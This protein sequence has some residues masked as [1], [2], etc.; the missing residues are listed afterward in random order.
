VHHARKAGIAAETPAATAIGYGRS[1]PNIEVI[2]SDPELP[3][4]DAAAERK[5]TGTTVERAAERPH[6]Q[7]AAAAITSGFGEFCRHENGAVNERG[8][9]L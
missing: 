2:F 4:P 7:A 9:A 5:G 6:W 1:A 3:S 8:I